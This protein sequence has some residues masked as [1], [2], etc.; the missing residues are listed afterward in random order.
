MIQY[1][2]YSLTCF[3]GNILANV[4]PLRYHESTLTYLYTNTY[5]KSR[6]APN[7]SPRIIRKKLITSRLRIF[8]YLQCSNNSLPDLSNCRVCFYTL[9]TSSFFHQTSSILKVVPEAIQTIRCFLL[10]IFEKYLE[11][12]KKGF[13]FAAKLQQR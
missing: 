2:L 6:I 3:L 4:S 13:I 10:R 9:V 11:I 7:G 8:F 1:I 5:V 12:L